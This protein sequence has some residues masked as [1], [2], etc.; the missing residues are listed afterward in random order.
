[1]PPSPEASTNSALTVLIVDDDASIRLLVSAVLSEEGFHVV[2]AANGAEAL[3]QVT[4]AHPGVI[5]LDLEMPVMDGRAFFHELRD[6]GNHTPVVILSANGARQ[7][8]RE[9]GAEGAIEKPFELVALGNEVR[10]L[11]DGRS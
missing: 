7:A 9:L 11:A 2:K 6:V 5:V 1:M 10:R 8:Q 4:A 3:A